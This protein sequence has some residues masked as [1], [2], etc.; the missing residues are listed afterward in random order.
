[1]ECYATF[2]INEIAW[3]RRFGAKITLFSA[4]RPVPQTD[5]IKDAFR[6]ESL[7]FEWHYR[8]VLSANLLCLLR[9]PLAYFRSLLL[10]YREG[11]SLRMLLLAAWYARIV[12]REGIQHLHGT[13]GTRTTTLACVIARLAGR[14]FSFT[15]HAYDIFRPNPSLVWKTN[16]A[17]FMRTISLFNKQYIQDTYRGVDGSKIQVVYLGVNTRAFAPASPAPNPCGTVRLVSVGDLIEKKGHVILVRACALLA[18]QGY[19]FTCRIIG[20]GRHH[21]AV[22]HEISQLEIASHVEL[23]GSRAHEEV[24]RLLH[25]SEVFVL[26]CMDV[27]AQ[28]EDLDGIP[29]ALMEAMAMGMPVVSTTISGIPELIEDGVSGLLV[30]ERDEGRLAD[31]LRRLIENPQLRTTLGKAARQR[32]EER[33]DLAANVKALAVLYRENR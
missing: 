4:F 6:R 27:R 10:L 31:A 8:G 5:P 9:A 19:R 20:E 24:R 7:Y 25:E 23:L 2:I 28:G 32:I 11:E 17:R 29:V 33:F 12:R 13:F 1:M 26:A 14:D 22:A 30:P 3:L 18:R 21:P 15:T 16:Q